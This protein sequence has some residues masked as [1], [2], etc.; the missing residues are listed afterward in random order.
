MNTEVLLGVTQGLALTM[1]IGFLTY[2]GFILVPYLRERPRPGGDPAD[3]DWHFLI[4]CC[5]EEY[6][7][8]DTIA[9]LRA[10]FPSTNI[11]VIDDASRD[12]TAAIVARVARNDPAVHLVRRSEPNAR[13]GK[14]EALNAGYRALTGRL[15]DGVDATRTI[16]VV[17]DADGRPAPG[18]LATCAA[19]HLFGDP[20]MGGVQIGVWMSNRY[21]DEPFPGRGRWA[22]AFGRTLVRLQDLEFRAPIS[23]MQ[24][25]RRTTGTVG[26]GGNGQ[27]TRLSALR[28]VAGDSGAPWRGSLLEDFEIGLHLL[29]AGYR[30][31]Y[32][33]EA[34]VFQEGLPNLRRLLTQRTRWGQGTMQCIRYL[35][36]IWRSPYISTLG[37]AEVLYYLVQPWLQLLG[38]LVYPL[39]WILLGAETFRQPAVVSDWFFDGPGW[40]L[41]AIYGTF[42]LLPFVMWGPVY[43]MVCEPNTS[44]RGAAGLGLAFALYIY[45][46]YI[47]SWRAVI[48]L[49]LR[50]NSW[51]KTRRNAEEP[52]T[53]VPA[54]A[55]VPRPERPV[56]T[57]AHVGRHR[58]D[59]RSMPASR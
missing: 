46:F 14:G 20:Q 35:P 22:N 21:E 5:D 29:M 57:P 32:T 23:A 12:G 56:P 17:V 59:A 16:V 53:V 44:R 37:A 15:G 52:G 41:F 10:T 28:K 4:P 19:D 51:S 38:S 9:Y 24:I 7:I 55:P 3:F 47:T 27:F 26:L 13:V 39:P 50:R 54:G 30:V 25:G 58:L 1:S 36:R 31:E 11:W 6:V 43:R 49:V 34:Y 48:R 18:C 2:V 8:A 40:I 33:R 45:I 42:G